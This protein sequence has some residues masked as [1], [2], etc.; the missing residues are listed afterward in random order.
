[1]P[2][3]TAVDVE[4]FTKG[5]LLASSPE[6]TRVLQRA[7]AAV[8]AYCGWHVTPVHVGDVVTLD[9]PG[10]LRLA[11]PTKKL[12][13]LTSVVEDGVTLNVANLTPS[14]SGRQLVKTVWPY[15]WSCN[16]RSIVVTMT[17]GF[18]SAPDFDQA[19]LE[20][21][22]TITTKIGQVGSL[23]RDRV[24]DVD[25]EW[26]IIP[27]GDGEYDIDQPNHSLLDQYRLIPAI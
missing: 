5:R 4:L 15:W 16:F 26:H 6:T 2:E 25:R 18:D 1:M 7:Y 27:H 8:R 11:L 9:G 3:L 23:R 14:A 10:G 22:D 20:A 17:H 13:T 21:V 19:V 12:I 24:D